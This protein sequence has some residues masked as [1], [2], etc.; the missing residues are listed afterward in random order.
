MLVYV[1]ILHKQNVKTMKIFGWVMLGLLALA[2]LF[3]LNIV[4]VFGKHVTNS[5]ENAVISY[6]EYQNIY[7]TCNKLN[8]DL[9]IMQSTPETDKQFSDFSK[10]QRINTI[11]MTLNRWI[12]EYNAKSKHIDKK[13]WKSSELPYQLDVNQ[14][15]NYNKPNNN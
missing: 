9:G 12:E 8:T 11:K 1:V 10:S 14:F 6:D 5:V 7:Y 15:T 13:V 3:T 4:G 2:V